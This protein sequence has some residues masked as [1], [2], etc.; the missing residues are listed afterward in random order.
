MAPADVVQLAPARSRLGATVRD[1]L[2]D[3]GG[4]ATAALVALALA[5]VAWQ[6]FRWGGPD[7]ETLIS[8]VAFL[9]VSITGAVLAWRASRLVSLDP[10]SRRAWRIVGAAFFFYW[11]GDV[12]WTVEENL[13][14]APYPSAADAAYLAFYGILLW[15]VLTFPTAP[16][17]KA[18][19]T[20]LWLD[21]GTVVIGAYM[22]LWYFA[23]GPTARDSGSTLLE[24]FVSLAYPIGDLVLVF[25]ITRILLSQPSRGLGRS[26]GIL[27][28]G[29]I[30]FVIADV[31]FAHLSFT[32]SY[33]GG[34]WPDSLW[35]VAQVLM[36]LSAQ[37][38]YWHSTRKVTLGVVESVRIRTFSP[39]PY[40]AVFGSFGLLAVVAWH[41]AAYPLGGLMLGALGITMLVVSRQITALR[42][43]LK[44]LAELHDLASTDMLTGLHSRRHL[45]EIAEREFYLARRHERHLSA[46]MID[47]DHFKSI[48]DTFGHAAGDEALQTL[49]RLCSESLR[50]TDLI[51]RYGG[52]ELVTILPDTDVEHAMEA[53]ARIRRALDDVAI[54]SEDGE[55]RFTIS[56]GIA[57]AEAAADLAQLLRRAD[58]ALYQAKQDGRNTTRALSA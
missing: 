45:F 28:S 31:A 38:K 20:K 24:S 4:W 12:V 5:F 27:A 41:E 54:A 29:L 50:T 55:F 53:A 25:A 46:M 44:L 36:A 1:W 42:E 14:N 18:D 23:L 49:A 6:I 11:I 19:R 39:L 21:T 56:V 48:N 32:D 2:R 16:K 51:G 26:L 43:N 37:Y 22:I 9:P 30:L 15:G 7:H 40:V 35:M 10:R 34:D 58:R 33:A 8:D 52:D 47:I 57:T 3:P 17:T 13:G